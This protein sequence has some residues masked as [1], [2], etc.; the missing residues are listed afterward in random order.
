MDA[1][2]YKKYK[3]EW[4]KRNKERLDA[5]ARAWREKNRERVREYDRR[6]EE[7]RKNDPVLL[8]KK[9]E[10]NRRYRS[11]H[12]EFCRGLRRK[13]YAENRESLKT[14]AK[15]W[16]SHISK[17]V[18]DWLGGKCACCGE[19]RFDM[20]T[21]DHIVPV[22]R[23]NR[24]SHHADYYEVWSAYRSC[25]GAAIG[26]VRQKY[27]ILCWNCNMSKMCGTEC[28]HKRGP[29]S[30]VGLC[31]S[32]FYMREVAYNARQL[33]G[34]KCACCGETEPE[35][36]CI[37]HI[38]DDGHL[39]PR[40]KNGK[41]NAVKLYCYIVSIF[42]SKD[43]DAIAKLESRLQVLCHNCNGSKMANGGEC[44]HKRELAAVVA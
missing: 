34:G 42:K 28:R 6:H 9:R 38:N 3:K 12:L 22:G 35:F 31:K 16:R 24:N 26:R 39:E 10:K 5:Y 21:I 14:Y 17:M 33:L 43:A 29:R 32:A 41:R 19:T 30:T 7:K 37:D 23:K 25:D 1:D 8:E 11:R 20:L 13:Y 36:L 15:N 27:Q 2:Y 18:K 40:D 44:S 4:Y